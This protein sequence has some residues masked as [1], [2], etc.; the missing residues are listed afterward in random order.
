MTGL[1]ASRN[2]LIVE[3]TY[4]CS[5]IEYYTVCYMHYNRYILTY[6]VSEVFVLVH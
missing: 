6:I 4:M 3:Q 2:V 5:Y 1:V